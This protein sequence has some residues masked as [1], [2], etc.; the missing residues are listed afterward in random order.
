MP[1]WCDNELTVHDMTPELQAWLEENGFSFEKMAPLE[2]TGRDRLDLQRKA[3]GTKWDLDDE[4][5]RQVAED[6]LDSGEANFETAWVPPVRA[7][8]S[9]SAKFP[10]ATFLL[11][12][13]EPGAGIAGIAAI[14]AGKQVCEHHI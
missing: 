4:E 9:L 5:Q 8:E 11:H 3:W 10:E 7:I 1:N 13:N 2:E 6:L 14:K 12:Y